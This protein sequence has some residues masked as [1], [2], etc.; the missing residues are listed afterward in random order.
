[1]MAWQSLE[2][3][4]LH[5]PK[6]HLCEYGYAILKNAPA[7]FITGCSKMLRYKAR[8]IIRNEAYFFVRRSEA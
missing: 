2:P 8:D 4:G 7:G 6:A 5:S 1:M 3:H